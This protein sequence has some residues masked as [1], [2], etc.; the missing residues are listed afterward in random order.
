[1]FGELFC[2]KEDEIQVFFFLCFVYSQPAHVLPKPGYVIFYSSRKNIVFVISNQHPQSCRELSLN[3][4]HWI[5]QK[6][7]SYSGHYVCLCLLMIKLTGFIPAIF[8]TSFQCP[9]TACTSEIFSQAHIIALRTEK[10]H[11][12]F[13]IS[14]VLFQALTGIQIKCL[15]GS[16]LF[17]QCLLCSRSQ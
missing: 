16:A 13:S 7:S 9:I 2:E 10:Q 15:N 6:Q 5:P 8:L 12:L 1:M 14:A 11:Q 3:T 17:P 4:L